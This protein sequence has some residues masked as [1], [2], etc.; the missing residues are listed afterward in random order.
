MTQIL[1]WSGYVLASSQSSI[2]GDAIKVAWMGY[3]PLLLKI[4]TLMPQRLDAS[5]SFKS[6]VRY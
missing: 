3:Q 1:L 6:Q 5:S 2:N 4:Q